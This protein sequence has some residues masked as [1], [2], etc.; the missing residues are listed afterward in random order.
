MGIAVDGDPDLLAAPEPPPNDPE[1]DHL[2]AGAA[3]GQMLAQGSCRRHRTEHLCQLSQGG[4]DAVA[5][6]AG[7]GP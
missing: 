3:L 5:A 1:P 6:P 7:R 2:A 4:G